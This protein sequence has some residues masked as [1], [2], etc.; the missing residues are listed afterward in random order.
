MR[1][2]RSPYVPLILLV[3]LYAIIRLFNL[4]ILPIF[5]D[6]SI[7]IYW[8]KLIESTHSQW[9]VSLTDGKPP[10]L[11]WMI[12]SFLAILPDTWYLIAGRL[13]AVLAGAV[14][15][16]AIYKLTELLFEKRSTAVIASIL[17]IIFPFTLLYDRMALFDSPLQAALL[18]STFFALKTART[19][20]IKYAIAWGV[21]LGIAFLFKPTAL[22][23]LGL[24]IGAVIL[25]AYSKKQKKWG[26]VAS[27]VVV[28][29]VISEVINNL[30]RV[31]SVYFMAEIKNAQFQQPIDELLRNP[32][33]L[34]ISNMH[35]FINW[36]IGYYTIPF[37]LLGIIGI[38][39]LLV[40]NFRVGVLLLGLW[41]IPILAL[42]TIGREIFPRYMLF[43]TPYFLIA[44]AFI[45]VLLYERARRL[46]FVIAGL[47][48]VLI[49]PFLITN[50]YILT[51]P[52]KAS[53]PKTDYDQL[54]A[55]HPSGYGVSRVY[56]SI[57]DRVAIGQHV[58][59][60]TQGTFG[61]YPYAFM[62]EYWNNPHVTVL[63]RWPLDTIDEE[64]IA[65]HNKT[66]VLI[67]LKEHESIPENLPLDLIEKIEKPGGAYP[68]LLTELK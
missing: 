58:T 56:E 47:G 55:T 11:I 10:L 46:S 34:T 32:F 30:Q 43:T 2:F 15:V 53:L 17:Y 9:F 48:I 52:T 5:T 64:V 23:F 20:N 37:L 4:T 39:V 40:K 62:L 13:P 24:L 28:A 65:A 7:Y 44:V 35:G 1:I 49:I 36:M 3:L 14:S 59:L 67:L 33:A 16:I 38:V 27:L 42:A 6:E 45:F 25:F 66:T 29:A 54:V 21:S 8:A 57:N 18:V 12:A 51:D 61:L 22:V 26:R 50:F 19:L 63:P 68:I 31:S 60:V 41:S